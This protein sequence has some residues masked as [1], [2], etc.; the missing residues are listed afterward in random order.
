MNFT[1]WPTSSAGRPSAQ[2]KFAGL[3]PAESDGR[4]NRLFENL[5]ASVCR[6]SVNV[7]FHPRLKH[8][9]RAVLAIENHRGKNLVDR[10]PSSLGGRELPCP[11]AGLMLTSFIPTSALRCRGFF[12]YAQFT[13]P[14]CR[15]AGM[16]LRFDYDHSV[17][18]SLAAHTFLGVRATI[19]AVPHA[20]TFSEF[21]P[22]TR[23]STDWSRLFQLI[24]GWSEERV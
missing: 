20:Q 16:D 13:P 8:E 23:I 7:H 24:R 4:I 9:E 17:P 18:S 12:G 15:G 19:L 11:P 14:P 21:F 2:G 3:K 5:F 6:Y 1:A 22:Y 10:N